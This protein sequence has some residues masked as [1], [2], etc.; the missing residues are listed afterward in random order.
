ML[1]YACCRFGIMITLTYSMML[2]VHTTIISLKG[3]Q[4]FC[5]VHRQFYN[6]SAFEYEDIQ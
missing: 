2:T 1:F 4:C 3:I 5:T 6:Y